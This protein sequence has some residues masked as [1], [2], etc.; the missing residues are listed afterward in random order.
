MV[1]QNLKG[2]H[3]G[4]PDHNTPPPNFFTQLEHIF[5]WLHNVSIKK[6]KLIFF[7]QEM[8]VSWCMKRAELILKCV[9]GNDKPLE[10]KR[11]QKIGNIRHIVTIINLATFEA[12]RKLGQVNFC[13]D[14]WTIA[15]DRKKIGQ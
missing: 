6:I 11:E 4:L 13:K 2:V 1:T 7:S 5:K 8:T 9:K 15:G 10:C 14:F 3:Y 12:R